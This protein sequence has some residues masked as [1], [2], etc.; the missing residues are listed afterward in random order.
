MVEST[1]KTTGIK[2]TLTVTEGSRDEGAYQHWFD[3]VVLNFED[4]ETFK[5]SG[6]SFCVSDFHYKKWGKYGRG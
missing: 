6:Y 5:G 3:H 1:E 2:F 4:T